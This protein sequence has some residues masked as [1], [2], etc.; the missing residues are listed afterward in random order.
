MVPVTACRVVNFA[1]TL[2][3]VLHVVAGNFKSGLLN[4][5]RGNKKEHSAYYR[6]EH[7]S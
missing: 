7:Q 1:G 5:L 4:T 6:M 3:K 2:M